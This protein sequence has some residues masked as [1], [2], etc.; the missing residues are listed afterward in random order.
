MVTRHSA[1]VAKPDIWEVFQKSAL[2]WNLNEAPGRS[3]IDNAGDSQGVS[4]EEEKWRS[5]NL[6]I[7]HDMYI[8]PVKRLVLEYV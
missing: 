4:R 1:A 6:T 5:S 8:V 7:Q 3:L 2:L